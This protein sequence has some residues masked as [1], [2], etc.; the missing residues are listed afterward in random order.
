MLQGLKT[1]YN[2]NIYGNNMLNISLVAQTGFF[3]LT[4]GRLIKRSIPTNDATLYGLILA[5]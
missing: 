1:C 4:L 5:S 2:F 3:L